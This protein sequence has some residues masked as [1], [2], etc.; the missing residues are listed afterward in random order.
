MNW[1]EKFSQILT[2]DQILTD[3]NN[4]ETYGKDWLKDFT[5]APSCVLLPKTS[6]EVQSIVRLCFKESIPLVPSGGRTGY[7][8]GA[9]ATNGE[10]ILSLERLN[11]IQEI[12]TEDCTVTCEAGVVTEV[13]QQ[14]VE[15]KSLY[16]PLDLA[17]KGSSQVGGNVATN[18]GGIHVLRYG[19]TKNWVLGAKVV[20]GS[21]ELLNLNRGLVK[22]QTGYNLLGLLTGSEGTLG[23]VVEVTLKLIP[24]PLDKQRIL[25]AVDDSANILPLL[26]RCRALFP[27]LSA[28]EYFGK[29]ALDYVLK[30]TDKQ[31]PFSETFGHYVLL[32]LESFELQKSEILEEKLGTLIEDSL[33]SDVIIAQSSK[34]SEELMSYRELISETLSAHYVPHKNDISVRVGDTIQLLNKLEA[35]VESNYDGY[36]VV[37]FG[38]IGDGNFHVTVLKPE[39]MS[40]VDFFADCRKKD[41]MLFTLVQDFGG[42]VSAEHGVG[43]LKKDFLHYSCSSEEIQLMKGIKAVFDPK[44]IL[45]PGKIFD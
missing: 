27:Y 8:G 20:T 39:E 14:K 3:P 45:N 21:G 44:G 38:H 40:D 43:L 22:N 19:N 7:S 37:V 11:K 36:S 18:A 42:S 12:N 17:S 4:L 23:V 31:S 16:F 24:K 13:L 10:V 28:F 32:E 5:P 35:L 30:H 15:D 34:Q 2:P 1:T 29:V 6:L 9:T 26:Q 41:E 25:V 33:V